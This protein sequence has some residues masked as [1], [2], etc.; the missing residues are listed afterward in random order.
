MQKRIFVKKGIVKYNLQLLLQLQSHEFL[1][2]FG[3]AFMWYH[4]EF[5]PLVIPRTPSGQWTLK[6]DEKA[7][8][9]NPSGESTKDSFLKIK[10]LNKRLV[11]SLKSVA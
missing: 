6:F 9:R 3:Q 1:N 8:C 5:V 11:F 2:S 7:I 4:S 10:F